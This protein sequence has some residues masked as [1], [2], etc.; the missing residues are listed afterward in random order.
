M[1]RFLC[2]LTMVVLASCGQSN[3]AVDQNSLIAKDSELSNGGNASAANIQLKDKTVKF[4]WRANQYDAALKDSFNMIC[5]DEAICKTL[6][7][8]ERAALGYV[9]TFIGNECNWDGETKEDRSNLKCKILTALNLGYQCSDQHLG[10][11]RQW[12]REDRKVIKAL[13]ECPTT[14]FTATSQE[15]FEEI[16]MTVKGADILIFYKVSGS[17]LR[18]LSSWSYSETDHFQVNNNQLQ[19][20]KE[21]KS[22]ISR[23][24]VE[25]EE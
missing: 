19:L 8:P 25:G 1:T 18:D 16:T 11:L 17:N 22:T 7:D 10:F 24:K 15:T 13:E 23:N 2:L 3:N 20:I 14:P 9:A 21:E 12:F 5:L 6:S 4:L